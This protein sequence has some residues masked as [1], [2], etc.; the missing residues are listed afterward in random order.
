MEKEKI[1]KEQGD[2]IEQMEKEMG[3]MKEY[4]KKL[5]KEIKELK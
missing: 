4:I 2:K 5:E 3:L 1:I